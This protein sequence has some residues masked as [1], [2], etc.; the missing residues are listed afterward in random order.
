MH[1][2]GILEF[3]SDFDLVWHNGR[4]LVNGAFGV[5]KEDPSLPSFDPQGEVRRLF[6]AS[7]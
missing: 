6:H 3:V 2:L 4:P 5:P 1:R 7:E